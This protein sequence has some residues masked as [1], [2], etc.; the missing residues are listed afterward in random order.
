[1]INYIWIKKLKVSGSVFRDLGLKRQEFWFC[2]LD[3]FESE[4]IDEEALI[5]QRRQQR[6]AIVQVC[7]RLP[8]LPILTHRFILKIFTGILRPLN[9]CYL[10]R[11]RN[12]RR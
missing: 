10:P 7:L 6:L 9:V 11:N 1:M 4:E 12:T 2:R 8:L 3:E 5:E